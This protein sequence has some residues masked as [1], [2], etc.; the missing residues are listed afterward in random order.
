MAANVTFLPRCVTAAITALPQ[1]PRR[2]KR[3]KRKGRGKDGKKRDE[4]NGR[5]TPSPEIKFG[6]RPHETEDSKRGVVHHC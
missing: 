4:R 3:E 1:I 6:S 5:K 2:K